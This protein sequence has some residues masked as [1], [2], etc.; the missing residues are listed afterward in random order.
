[1]RLVS[2]AQKQES[3]QYRDDLPNMHPIR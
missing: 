2:V 1:L 3:Q